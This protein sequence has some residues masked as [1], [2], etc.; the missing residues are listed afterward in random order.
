MFIYCFFTLFTFLEKTYRETCSGHG[1]YLLSKC[2]CDRF[3][4]GENCQ[5]RDE[6]MDN[7]DC[8]EMGKCVDLDTTTPPRKQCYCEMGWFGLN[9]VKS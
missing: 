1:R 7:S 4:Y 5:Y 2:R 8:G 6:C 3:F 9:C